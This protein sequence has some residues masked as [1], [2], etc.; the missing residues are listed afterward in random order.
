[1]TPHPR[2]PRPPLTSPLHSQSRA[3]SV[4]FVF[5]SRPTLAACYFPRT[6][7]G[8]RRQLWWPPLPGLGCLPPRGSSR[9]GR[10]CCAINR[11]R[12]PAHKNTACPPPTLASPALAAPPAAA[13][14]LP[15]ARRHRTPLLQSVL[16]VHGRAACL[17]TLEWEEV[18]RVVD[19]CAAWSVPHFCSPNPVILLPRPVD[20]HTFCR[21][22]SSSSHS[23]QRDC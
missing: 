3:L 9:P 4:C 5:Q 17:V 18:Q 20:R 8:A 21:A 2:P 6:L 10:A 15:P 14:R 11:R 19:L 1:V 22:P 23:Q 16:D 13:R 7:P 12:P